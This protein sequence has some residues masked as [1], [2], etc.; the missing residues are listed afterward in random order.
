[1]LANLYC[2]SQ[3]ETMSNCPFCYNSSNKLV[4][5]PFLSDSP[6]EP[7]WTIRCVLDFHVAPGDST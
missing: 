6:G 1:L 5:W 4:F 7:M 3:Y 2:C